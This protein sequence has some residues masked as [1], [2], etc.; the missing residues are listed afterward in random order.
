MGPAPIDIDV[1]LRKWS[2]LPSVRTAYSS[3]ATMVNHVKSRG[4]S[5]RRARR[6]DQIGK[7]LS[8]APHD[9]RRRAVESTSPRSMLRRGAGGSPSIEVAASDGRNNRGWNL[10]GGYVRPAPQSV[11]NIPRDAGRGGGDGVTPAARTM[12]DHRVMG[13]NAAPCGGSATGNPAESERDVA[14]KQGSTR[15]ASGSWPIMRPETRGPAR[16]HLAPPSQVTEPVAA[17]LAGCAP[18]TIAERRRAR[19][20]Q[21]GIAP[22]ATAASM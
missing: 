20:T 4:G 6:V 5:R 11:R 12:I 18:A 17:A 14:S 1:K 15:A 7:E 22:N 3:G 21:K 10:P 19:A 9:G 16:A 13:R 8:P 2:G